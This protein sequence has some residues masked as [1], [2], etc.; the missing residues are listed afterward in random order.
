MNSAAEQYS[1]EVQRADKLSV[2]AEPEAQL[3]VPI[4]NLL[5]AI[6]EDAEIG[7]LTLL[8]EAQLDGV[9][10]DFAAFIDKSPCGWIELKAPGHT[11]DGTK[12]RG[13]EKGQ[14]ELL[15]QLDSLIVTNGEEAALYMEGTLA[16]SCQLPYDNPN[17]WNPQPLERLLQLFTNAQ[18]TPIKRVSQLASRLAP[19]AKFIRLRLDE[20]L[21]KNLAAVLEAKD[22]WDNTVHQTTSSEQFSSDIAQVIAYSMA[23]AGLSGNADLNQDGIISLQE[24]KNTLANSHRNVLSAALGPVLGIPQF[25]EYISAEVGAIVRLVSCIDLHAIAHSK[26]SRGEPW[27]WFYEDFLATYDPEARKQSGVY[28][29][30]ISV[31][32][33]QVR[34]VEHLLRT[35]FGKNLG[36]AASSVVTL[37]PATGSGTYPIAIIDQAIKTAIEERGPAGQQQAAATLSKNL[38]AFE[39][40]PGPYSVAHLRIGQRLAD[41]QG[42]LAHLDDLGVFLTDTLEDP[43]GDIPTG[44]FGDARILAEAAQKARDV[45]RQRPITVAIGNP[46]YD[47]VTSDTGGWV[48]SGDETTVPLFDDVIKP[49]QED[50]VIFSA[51]ASLYNLYV[52]FWRWAIWKAFEQPAGGKEN[53]AIISFIT[54]SSWLNGPAFVGLRRL[55]IKTASEIWITDLGGE[56]R[57]ARK[58]ENVFSIQSPVAIVTLVKKGKASKDATVHYRRIR[59]TRNEKFAQLD[60]IASFN[61]ADSNWETLPLTDDFLFTTVPHSA[62]WKCFLALQDAFPLQQPGM[63]FN[64]MWPISPSQ[65]VLHQRWKALLTDTDT[66][67]RAEKFVTATTGRTIHSTISSHP[68]LQPIASLAPD[69]DPQPVVR[70]GWRSFDTQF[71]F[72]DPR[73]INLERPALW[74]SMSD[75]QIFIVS[76][77]TARMSSGPAATVSLGVPDKHY[78]CNRGGKDVIPLYRDKE[79]TQSNIANGLL[80]FLRDA[81]NTPITPE[82]FLC[83]AYA[84]IAHG[85]YTEKFTEELESSAARFPITKSPGLFN[86]ACEIGRELLWLHTFGERFTSTSR[87]EMRVPRI[88]GIGWKTPVTAIPRTVKDVSYDAR[89]Q[90]LHVGDGI[91][92]GVKREVMEFSVSGMNILD[93]WLGA[94]TRKGIGRAASKNAPLLDQI[95]PEEWED[96]WNDELLDLIRVLT[97]TLELGDTQMT[98]LNQI[99]EGEIFDAADLPKPTEAQRKVPKTIKQQPAN[100]ASLFEG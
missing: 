79:A 73:L 22:A 87:P 99:L 35:K 56:G 92:T 34:T 100:S 16:D 42:H 75:K 39:L 4:S 66:S 24:A 82:D 95:R 64:R 90:E 25:A 70:I 30:P 3:T 98:V 67:Q 86:E 76:P 58:E 84:L 17:T 37:D 2:S 7:T 9:R 94:R 97:R 26:D 57:G 41:A 6:A 44:L 48:T 54:A 59:G 52:Y 60:E 38:L 96:E 21:E 72:A 49:A 81:Y 31:V 11:L 45:K 43:N 85:G 55:A 83:Y 71:C 78:F 61:L 1:Y 88:K 14:W 12:W 27:L 63:M 46:P 93:K 18:P 50:G 40:L 65:G 20:G 68:H 33:Y 62:R 15:S 80:D 36:F 29:T 53:D 47:R 77:Y 8:R 69:A 89:T 32:Q 74:Q 91:V 13:R 28:Y 5:R 23:I 19:L 51:Q 10:P